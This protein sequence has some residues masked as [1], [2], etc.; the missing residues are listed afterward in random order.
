MF[1]EE[2]PHLKPLPESSFSFFKISKRK[3]N[4]LDSHIEVQGAFYPV[5]P[6]YMGGQVDVHFNSQWVKVLVNGKVIQWLSAIEKGRFHPDKR[7]LPA[8][9]A[10][11]RNTYQK[12]LLTQCSDLGL[13]IR[14]WAD[15]A[16]VERGLPAY[17]SIQGALR[18]TKKYSVELL[19]RAC[20]MAIKRQSFSSK[21]IHNYLEELSL[22]DQIQTR[23]P[24][25]LEND[26]IRTPKAYANLFE[27]EVQS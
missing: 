24:L 21:L 12:N 4:S 26:I 16:V 20:V 18:L 11:D 23:L 3:V 1:K 22:Q 25:Q 17:R 6:R 10:M 14:R 7:S 27:Q 8:N 2:Q 19:D 13:N 5:P 9:K 15:L